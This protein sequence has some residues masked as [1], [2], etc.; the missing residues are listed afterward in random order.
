MKTGVYLGP[1]EAVYKDLLHADSCDSR[2]QWVHAVHVPG[3][4]CSPPR[5]T[6]YIGLTADGVFVE[7]MMQWIVRATVALRSWCCAPNPGTPPTARDIATRG[8]IRCGQ[9]L[10]RHP[11]QIWTLPRSCYHGQL[12]GLLKDACAD[13]RKLAAQVLRSADDMHRYFDCGLVVLSAPPRPRRSVTLSHLPRTEPKFTWK[14]MVTGV[15]Q[16]RPF[17]KTRSTRCLLDETSVE[18]PLPGHTIRLAICARIVRLLQSED[19][20]S[21]ILGQGVSMAFEHKVAIAK[22]MNERSA[23]GKRADS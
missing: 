3:H 2:G 22:N 19:W 9:A 20:Q 23:P 4:S 8:L 17:S 15:D 11:K 13:V 21:V 6:Y 16:M 18:R 12:C 10:G 5:S 7:T 14:Y 1:T